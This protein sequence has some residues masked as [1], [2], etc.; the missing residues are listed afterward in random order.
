MADPPPKSSGVSS[1]SE[2]IFALPSAVQSLSE[3]VHD[4]AFAKQIK[5]LVL[6]QSHVIEEFSNKR[7]G[8]HL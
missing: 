7:I 8:V 2:D 5:R 6:N 4:L 3:Q 1:Q